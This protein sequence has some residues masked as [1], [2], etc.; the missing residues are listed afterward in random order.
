MDNRTITLRNI[1][2][3][4]VSLATSELI[5]RFL[6]GIVLFLLPRYLGPDDYGVY[7]L[8]L[9]F[10]TIFTVFA[11]YGLDAVFIKEVSRNKTLSQQYFCANILIKGFLSFIA[12]MVLGLLVYIL[13][14][15]SRTI[16][17]ILLL[18]SAIFFYTAV[19]TYTAVF[20][21]YEKMEYNAI[22]E[23]SRSI[24]AVLAILLAIKLGGNV[25]WMVIIPAITY[26]ILALFGFILINKNFFKIVWV[27]DRSFLSDTFKKSTP[28]FLVGFIA[29]IQNKV[30]IIMM[31]KLANNI[32]VGLFSA[33]NELINIIYIIPSLVSTV[34]F[35]VFSRQYHHSTGSLLSASNLS[36]KYIAIIG[37]PAS[38]GIYF[39]APQII[40]LIYGSTFAG[41]IEVL[42]ILGAGIGI[43]FV[44]N[45]I[46]Y[47]LAAA[48]RVNYVMYA[49]MISVVINI[50]LNFLLIPIWGSKGAAF[51]VLTCAIV[52][53]IYIYS[54]F[55][56][57]FKGM[58]S[59]KIFVKPL[60]ATAIMIA[61]IWWINTNMVF[62]LLI[63]VI[64]YGF[65]I[66]T[67]KALKK[68]ELVMIRGM[69][70]FLS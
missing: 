40:N 41:S 58:T 6:G 26:L 49:N 66:Y 39:V 43:L 29:I 14:Y 46:S 45:I 3:N 64:T 1:G 62:T 37:F 67:L 2:K 5:G 30:D 11:C 34:L 38:A 4:I 35:P 50:G 25:L 22:L 23:I 54:T 36:I 68:E 61:M 17:A 44:A 15:S 55:K 16:L 57:Y 52:Q 27:V 70:P 31:S 19:K 10:F 42:Q 60:V 18:S 12:I 59:L 47:V 20:R 33:A 48:E 53:S 9:S 51:A 8:S 63:G 69:I 28:F 7:S 24:I 32:E 21:A 13:N 65:A 56:F